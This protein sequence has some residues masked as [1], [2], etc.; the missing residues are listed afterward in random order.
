MRRGAAF[1]ISIIIPTYNEVE[2]VEE[3]VA[4][5]NQ[6]LGEQEYD[7]E[8]LIVDDDS[9]DGTAEFAKGLTSTIPVRAHV[10]SGERSLALAVMEGFALARGDICV[11]MDADLSHPVEKIPELVRPILEG[12]CDATVGS[13]YI[14]GGGCHDWP[15]IRRLCSRSAGVL[16]RGLT[17][18]SDPTTGF[19][20]FRKSILNGVELEPVGWKIVLEVITRTKASFIEVP[21]VFC[22]RARGKSKLEFKVHGEYLRH[23]C[24]LYEYRFTS[25]SEFVKFCL[26]GTSGFLVDTFILV[27]LVEFFLLD[28]RLAAVAGFSAAV[29]WNF[30]FD[31]KWTFRRVISDL[32]LLTF[33]KFFTVCSFGL[34]VRVGIMHLLI[35]H[36]AM[37]SG[38]RYL[39][40]SFIGILAATLINFLGTKRFVFW[41]VASPKS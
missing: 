20:A 2:N 28:P 8:I 19:M 13:R 40:A 10:R 24:R 25:I 21:I 14:P 33:S 6:V 1:V 22:D 18:L 41:R 3:L 30:F 27:F 29:S 5:I 16:A 15:F 17:R 31:R 12:S 37:G 36:C 9:P 26:V 7:T 38:F 39:L 23:L 32:S 34:V 11:V 4:R 35:E